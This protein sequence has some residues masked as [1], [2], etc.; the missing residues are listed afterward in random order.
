MG[1]QLPPLTP[2]VA[3]QLAK[4]DPV[5]GQNRE[6]GFT[7]MYGPGANKP[8]GALAYMLPAAGMSALS[9]YL[10]YQKYKQDQAEREKRSA[11]SLSD[12]KAQLPNLH[13]PDL[14]LGG[15]AGAGAGALYDYI[16]GAPK[17][18]RLASALK[19]ILGGAAIGAGVSNLAGDRLRRYIT[20][21]MLPF[22]YDSGDTLKQLMP[23]SLSHVRDALIYDK[24]SYDPAAIDK[25]TPYFRNKDTFDRALAAR[26]ELNRISMGVDS[27]DPAKSVWQRNPGQK[28]P[29]YYSLNEKSPEY[30]Q[31]LSALMLPTR[32]PP[33]SAVPYEDALPHLP[34]GTSK[35]DYFNA[36]DKQNGIDIT[37][38]FKNPLAAFRAFNAAEHKP[39]IDL[40]GS[41]S[42]LGGQQFAVREN[43]QNVEGM[44][45]DRFDI[46]PTRPE[47]RGFLDAIRTGNIFKPSWRNQ[48]Q[49]N[50]GDY[51]SSQTNADAWRGVLA[52]SVWDNVLTK[53]HPWIAQPFRFTPDAGGRY[54]LEILRQNGQPAMP[55]IT[56]P[57]MAN[58]LADLASG[59]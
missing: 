54:A 34:P 18:Q 10:L 58:R 3:S 17:G 4:A 53:E 37:G 52:R 12:I 56:Q 42:L 47:Y 20:N 50:T 31:N 30:L 27:H 2:D 46:T 16:R 49:P 13:A 28:G 55:A 33:P 57:D 19:R 35:E 59:Q 39:T 40:L 1:G 51:T 9:M 14:L 38:F 45:L 22:G 23:R 36:K 15:A 41:D 6:P 48:T 25:K 5:L 21:S 24:P 11:V 26:R 8:E 43:G 7:N 29:A 32:L 44:A